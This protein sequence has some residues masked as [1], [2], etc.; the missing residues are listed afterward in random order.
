MPTSGFE[1]FLV[2]ELHGLSENGR[3]QLEYLERL[4]DQIGLR[5]VAIEEDAV[6]EEAAQAFVDGRTARV[7]SPLCLRTD[8]LEGIRRLNQQLPSAERIRVHL[9]DID[10]PASAIRAHLESIRRQLG[11]SV[12]IPPRA[13]IKTRGLQAVSELRTLDMDAVTRS[14]LRTVELSIASYRQGLEIDRGTPKGSPYLDS[15]EEA[16]ASNILD[17]LGE[18]R[19]PSLL[20]LYGTD[21]VARNPRRDGGPARDRPFAPMGL[22]LQQAGVKAFAAVTFPLSGTSFWRGIRT[23]LPWT[24]ADGRLESGELLSSV[25][26]GAPDGDV[27]YIDATRHRPRLPSEDVSRMVVDAFVLFQSGSP[28]QERCSTH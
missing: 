11:A 6:Y 18:R 20:V 21:H 27:V 24:A 22:R 16:I 7:P 25:L 9:T 15:R 10:S 5:D 23:D 4:H 8:L 2:G 13:A 17:L 3:F 26:A 12:P 14:A 1:A 28:M 19:I